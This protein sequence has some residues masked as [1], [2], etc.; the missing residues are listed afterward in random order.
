[1]SKKTELASLTSSLTAIDAHIAEWV[2][3]NSTTSADLA[4]RLEITP[5]SLSS[6][7]NKNTEWKLSEILK[8][9][10]ILDCDFETLTS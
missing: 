5:A 3:R 1:M 8:L 10:R 4:E 6:K 2:R 7:R 9:M